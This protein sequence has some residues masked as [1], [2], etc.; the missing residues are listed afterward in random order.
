MLS[1]CKRMFGDALFATELVESNPL[2]YAKPAITSGPLDLSNC[3]SLTSNVAVVVVE[4]WLLRC[5]WAGPP[6]WWAC[7]RA[8]LLWS[9]LC[10]F[11]KQS[12]TNK[13][14]INK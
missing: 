13:E 11:N 5:G 4:G 2:Q 6:V 1:L 12:K 9:D 3:R 14:K 7:V 8:L 10:G